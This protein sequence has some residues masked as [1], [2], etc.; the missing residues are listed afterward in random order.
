MVRQRGSIEK[1]CGMVMGVGSES[2]K[3]QPLSW[4]L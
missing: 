1:S 4:W 2:G 3:A